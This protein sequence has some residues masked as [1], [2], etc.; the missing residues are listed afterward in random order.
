MASNYDNS[1]PAPQLQ[2][3]SDHNRSDPRI[4]DHI[5]EPSSSTLV[6]NV[7]PSADKTD[8]SLQDLD[9]L[10]SLI[11]EP[12]TPPTNVNGEENNI[13]QAA[14]AQFQPYE[15]INLLCTS[16]QEVVEYSSHS[17]DNSNMHTFGQR[18]RSDYHWTKD[19][20][21]EQVRGN[22]SRHVQTRRKLST[23][24]EM[25][26][27][28]LTEEVYV[29]HLDGFVDLDHPEKVYRLRKAL[30]G[31][32]QAP[33]AWYDKL[34]TFLMSKGFTKEA[35]Y[36][37]L[38]ASFAQVMW[39]RTQLKDYGFDYNII[40][41]Y[42]DSQSAIAISCNPVQHSRTK[43]ANVRYHYIKEQVERSLKEQVER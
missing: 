25:C 20:P 3:A 43:H 27:F 7:V 24:P 19:H 32:K 29:N 23:D 5:N 34:S 16:V 28:A 4:Q 13:D 31:L 38:S 26:M 22:P 2:K 10:F 40:P 33:R 6:P 37:S 36:M 30:Y 41:L 8:T 39:I 15:F 11:L 17:I 42:C 14:N 9:L 21:L 12:T 18:H 1:G 35:K